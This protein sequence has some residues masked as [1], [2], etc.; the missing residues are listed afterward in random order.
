MMMSG[1]RM[2]NN[3]L[4]NMSYEM[5]F[6][7]KIDH[8][9]MMFPIRISTVNVVHVSEDQIGI[10][11]PERLYKMSLMGVNLD[12]SYFDIEYR[13]N[14]DLLEPFYALIK[15]VEKN[16]NKGIIY[17]R[18]DRE[19]YLNGY[20]ED[21]FIKRKNMEYLLCKDPYD[22]YTQ[23]LCYLKKI[24]INRYRCT[25]PVGVALTLLDYRYIYQGYEFNYLMKEIESSPY[26]KELRLNRFPVPLNETLC[27]VRPDYVPIHYAEYAE[28]MDRLKQQ[29][30]LVYKMKNKFRNLILNLIGR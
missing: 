22:E 20:K 28:I 4:S 7:L 24:E 18:I 25:I 10:L 1:F 21:R 17:R 3:D 5:I 26:I 9:I 15:A 16:R 27:F 12:D 11:T 14:E 13:Y 6:G 23:T 29:K 30:T 2:K 8:I 19:K